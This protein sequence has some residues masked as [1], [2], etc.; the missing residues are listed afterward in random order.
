MEI[1]PI[2]FIISVI[3]TMIILYI[4]SPPPQIII[5]EPN[6]N[7]DTSDLFVD[8]NNVCYRYKTREIKCNI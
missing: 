7:Q 2:Y 6:I 4:L 1:L 3:V 8:D 5:K